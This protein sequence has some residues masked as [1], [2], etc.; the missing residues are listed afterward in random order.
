MHEAHIRTYYD[1]FYK[2]LKICFFLD[3]EHVRMGR[4]PPSLPPPKK[5]VVFL[6]MFYAWFL[7]IIFL[8]YN[9]F[10]VA[11]IIRYAGKVY[12]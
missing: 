10:F 3:S 11:A 2:W 6:V 7:K 5:N 4:M 1:Y 12:K 9:D 8:G